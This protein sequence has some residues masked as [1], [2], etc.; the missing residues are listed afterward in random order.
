MKACLA[1]TKAASVWDLIDWSLGGPDAVFF[2]ALEV[3]HFVEIIIYSHWSWVQN[4]WNVSKA[5]C[6]D[7]MCSISCEPSLLPLIRHLLWLH[8]SHAATSSLCVKHPPHYPQMP[9]L[10]FTHCVQSTKQ[11]V[12]WWTGAFMVWTA[13]RH[14]SNAFITAIKSLH[15]G[16]L[17]TLTDLSCL[18]FLFRA[19]D[20]AVLVWVWRHN[21]DKLSGISIKSGLCVFSLSTGGLLNKYIRCQL[22][23]SGKQV[24]GFFFMAAPQWV[25]KACYT[26]EWCLRQTFFGAFTACTF[27]WG[28]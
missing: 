16:W 21:K 4:W 14:Y 11:D 2:R 26:L 3:W 20:W 24:H 18:L 12:P 22:H 15:G 10:S 7:G 9:W 17:R 8:H 1:I 23:I 13:P 6:E 25:Q 19:I 28:H 27:K 5:H